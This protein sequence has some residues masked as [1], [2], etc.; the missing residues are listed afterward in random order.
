MATVPFELEVARVQDLLEL[1]RERS[2]ASIGFRR[3]TASPINVKP[4]PAMTARD[5]ARSSM[6][7]SS[8]NGWIAKI[9]L[10]DL[11]EAAAHAVDPALEAG[12]RSESANAR[13]ALTGRVDEEVIA[14]A[15]DSRSGSRGAGSAGRAA[16][17]S[18]R[19]LGWKKVV[20]KYSSQNGSLL[21]MKALGELELGLVSCD[22][23][24]HGQRAA[25]DDLHVVDREHRQA[26]GL[27]VEVRP[28]LEVA[29]HRYPGG[30]S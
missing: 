3:Y 20:M 15:V 19:T 11:V 8:L 22:G 21:L 28:R 14:A 23:H 7:L 12:L 13:V 24:L 18:L 2:P 6:N 25:I 1:A 9:A 17:V 30:S 10:H 29:D 4:P 5:D 27:A 16:C 26:V